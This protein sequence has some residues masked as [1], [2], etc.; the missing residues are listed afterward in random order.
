MD[1]TATSAGGVALVDAAADGLGRATALDL[2]DGTGRPFPAACRA[3][4][5][6]LDTAMMEQWGIPGPLKPPSAVAR[7]VRTRLE[8]NVPR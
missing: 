7:M 4:P 1:G 5:A 6:A 8:P 3:S 2:A